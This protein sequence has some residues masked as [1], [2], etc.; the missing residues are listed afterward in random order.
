MDP[1][2]SREY[3]PNHRA[4]IFKPHPRKR[5]RRRRRR[6]GLNRRRSTGGFCSVSGPDCALTL[7][8]VRQGA[9]VKAVWRNPGGTAMKALTYILYLFSALFMLSAVLIFLPWSTLNAWMAV[10]S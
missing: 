8:G 2:R 9:A 6:R 5:D 7:P 4:A 1:T 10:S 3:Q